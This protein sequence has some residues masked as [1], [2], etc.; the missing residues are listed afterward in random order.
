MS[1]GM[2][3]LAVDSGR[4]SFC[5]RV[6]LTGLIAQDSVIRIWDLPKGARILRAY[7]EKTTIDTTVGADLALKTTETSP[8]T[9][10]T[11]DISAADFAAMTV[12]KANLAA[13]TD[14]AG[15]N[16]TNTVAGTGDGVYV[17]YI[18]ATRPPPEPQ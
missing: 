5:V 11:L 18:E 8:R 17:V 3:D 7:I 9:L 13:F 15:V 16:L 6:G 14:D 4:L 1:R 2:K 10:A 12:N